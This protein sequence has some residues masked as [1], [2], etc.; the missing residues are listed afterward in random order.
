NAEDVYYFF[1]EW[2][3]DFEKRGIVRLSPRLASQR[4]QEQPKIAL[5]FQ[6]GF[7]DISFDF[8][9]LDEK[10]IDKALDALLDNQSYFVNK[11]GKLLVF[12]EETQKVSKV[13]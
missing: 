7:L 1:V 9:S 3:P 4:I 8:S 10:D 6:G 11:K 13:L 12:D 2:L 5:D